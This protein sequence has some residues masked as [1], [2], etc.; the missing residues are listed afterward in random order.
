MNEP[1]FEHAA[2]SPRRDRGCAARLRCAAGAE[3]E[4]GMEPEWTG[5]ERAAAR[6]ARWAQGSVAPSHR[7]F[8]LPHIHFIPDLLTG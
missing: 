5:G 1:R 3:Y 8:A 7:R 4:I 2:P 6:R